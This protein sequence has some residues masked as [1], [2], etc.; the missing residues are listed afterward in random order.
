MPGGGKRKIVEGYDVI[1]S[2]EHKAGHVVGTRGEYLIVEHGTLR[3]SRH[4]LPRTF[5]EV[6]DANRV[7]RATITKDILEDSPK[8]DG[9][10]VDEREVAAHYGLAAGFDDPE[11][12][13]YGEVLPDDP[14]LSAEQ[15]ELHLGL[16]TAEQERLDV[17]EG[18]G[19]EAH[20][21]DSPGLL[22]EHKKPR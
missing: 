8:L 20:E 13:G 18:R 15:E 19:T 12:K 4:L 3:K 17:L 16:R 7:I 14:G 22:G 5:V 6:D 1:T 10:E 9:D 21:P 11:T 2:D